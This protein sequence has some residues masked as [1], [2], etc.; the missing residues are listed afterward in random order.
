MQK[1]TSFN[2]VVIVFVK[3]NDYRTHFWSMSKNEA[4]N[5]MTNSVLKEK[6][7]TL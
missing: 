2:N 6:C 1:A 5:I 7:G 3:G 4:I